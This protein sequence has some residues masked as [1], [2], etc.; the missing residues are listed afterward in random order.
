MDQ[1]EIVVALLKFILVDWIN[2]VTLAVG[3]TVQNAEV[4]FNHWV[5]FID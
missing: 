3:K 1:P 5:L 2:D 4:E